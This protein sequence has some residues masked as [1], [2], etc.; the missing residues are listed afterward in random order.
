MHGIPVC[1][2]SNNVYNVLIFVRLDDWKVRN[3]FTESAFS[4]KNIHMVQAS[5]QQPKV[6]FFKKRK[7]IRD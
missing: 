6:I 1:N 5:T 2:D 7:K 3:S 4:R